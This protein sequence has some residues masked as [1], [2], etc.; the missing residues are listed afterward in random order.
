LK[1]DDKEFTRRVIFVR[2]SA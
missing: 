1:Y 2:Y